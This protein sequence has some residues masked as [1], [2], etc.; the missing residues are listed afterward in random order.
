MLSSNPQRPASGPFKPPSPD[1]VAPPLPASQGPAPQL[2]VAAPDAG[3]S[4]FRKLAFYMA[5]AMLFTRLTV[6]PEILRALTGVDTY[7][8][9]VVGPPA[10][11]GAVITGGLGRA[12]RHR[13]SYFWTA[14]FVCM[15]LATPFSYWPGGS[16]GLLVTY[17]RVEFPFL[18]VIAGL[19]TSWAEVRAVFNTVAVSAVV[20]LIT[21]RLFTTGE[22]G[23]LDLASVT[24]T[25][26]NANDLAAQL[27]LVLPFLGWIVLDGKRNIALRI[28]LIPLIA[29]GVWVIFGTASRGALLALCITGVY[30]FWRASL[31]RRILCLAVGGLMAAMLFTLVPQSALNRFGTLAGEE[32]K[33]A[34]ESAESRSYL[35]Q[36]SLKYTA[37][38]PLL[39]VGPDQFSNY[40]GQTRTA[41]GLRGAWHAT[42]CSWTQVSSEC[43]IPAALFFALGI[44]SAL[45]IVSRIRKTAVELGDPDIQAMCVCY[46]TAMVGF[47]TALTFLSNAYRFYFPVL[48]GLAVAM[49]FAAEAQFAARR[50]AA[51]QPA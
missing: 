25:I 37:Q 29:Y 11:L 21:A 47:L 8:L 17:A 43:G 26:G 42:H 12:Y 33:E 14:F 10:I 20:N 45:R 18:I 50:M 49:H 44:A 16:M 31:P 36:Q 28:G 23:R 39:G 35:F 30:L 27:V 4:P 46:L 51:V 24:G 32:D 3:D 1:V 9:Y 7:L 48:V 38:H 5:L 13:A 15:I 2:A 41:E 6:L 19:I 40:E 34:Q 22:T